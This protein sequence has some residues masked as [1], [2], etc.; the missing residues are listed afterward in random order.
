M[1]NQIQYLVTNRTLNIKG[2]NFE[3]IP[4]GNKRVSKDWIFND[5]TKWED[6][7][8]TEQPDA[9][10]HRKHSLRDVRLSPNPPIWSR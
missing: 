1:E 10:L 5:K 8:I 3:L 6:L 9:T 4:F 2:L 7:D